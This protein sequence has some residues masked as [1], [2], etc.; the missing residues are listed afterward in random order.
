MAQTGGPNSRF[1]AVMRSLVVAGFRMGKMNCV[2]FT[3]PCTGYNAALQ[4]PFTST[5]VPIAGVLVG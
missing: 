4:S 5:S 3:T 2:L 1:Q